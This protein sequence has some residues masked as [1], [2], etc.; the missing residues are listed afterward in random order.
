MRKYFF[1]LLIVVFLTNCTFGQSVDMGSWNILNI[2]YNLNNKWS[3]FGE[4]QLRS[5]K[6]Y[7]HFHYYEYKG[8][9]NFKAYKMFNFHLAWE[10]IKRIKKVEV[11]CFRKT[12]MNFVFGHKFY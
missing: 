11:L 6:F 12:M 4:T 10:V 5:L 3:L 7:S 1:K 9:F 2:Q 8:G